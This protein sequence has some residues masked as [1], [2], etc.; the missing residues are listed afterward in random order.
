MLISWSGICWLAY[1]STFTR[2]SSRFSRHGSLL[3]SPLFSSR[4]TVG[5]IFR[6]IYIYITI[7][8][9]FTPLNYI[10]WA[11]NCAFSRFFFSP[12]S[13]YPVLP[14]H[15][16]SIWFCLIIVGEVSW[17]ESPIGDAKK[18]AF[19]VSSIFFFFWDSR[20]KSIKYYGKKRKRVFVSK[21]P[22]SVLWIT[23]AHI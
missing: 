4:E 3:F 16:G 10:L 7:G 14:I 13:V 23:D 21:S 12:I 19:V 1:I 15:N 2:I 22:S 5:G 8:R 18:L 9:N 11:R 20:E 17:R 6:N